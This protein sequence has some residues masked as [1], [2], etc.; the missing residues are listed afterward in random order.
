MGRSS[1]INEANGRRSGGSAPTNPRRSLSGTM[2]VALLI[3]RSCRRNDDRSTPTK[4]NSPR[5]QPLWY[6]PMAGGALFDHEEGASR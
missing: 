5:K 4:V 2:S 1:R 6:Q 3:L